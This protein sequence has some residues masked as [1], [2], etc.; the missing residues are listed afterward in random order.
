MMEIRLDYKKEIKFKDIVN[1]SAFLPS[2][3][4]SLESMF[5]ALDPKREKGPIPDITVEN[6]VVVLESEPQKR[7]ISTWGFPADKVRNVT[8]DYLIH[9]FQFIRFKNNYIYLG[10]LNRSLSVFQSD[11]S[12]ETLDS[13]VHFSFTDTKF[14]GTVCLN[15]INDFKSF[16]SRESLIN[17]NLNQWW[18]ISH[19]GWKFKHKKKSSLPFRSIINHTSSGLDNPNYFS[20]VLFPES[21]ELIRKK[22]NGNQT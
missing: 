14:D 18:A 6:N 2:V 13:P 21:S 22:Y 12:L 9:T 20:K 16:P 10:L 8:F 4:S 11:K 5:Y 17:F 1:W 19:E 7:I 15:H 3:N